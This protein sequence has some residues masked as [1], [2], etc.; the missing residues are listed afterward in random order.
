M[1]HNIS[2]LAENERKTIRRTLLQSGINSCSDKA[3]LAAYLAE[4]YAEQGHTARAYGYLL[5]A[6]R[7]GISIPDN[8]LEDFA[9]EVRAMSKEDLASDYEAALLIGCELQNDLANKILFLQIAADSSDDVY[10]VAALK[11]ADL[12]T[13]SIRYKKQSDHYYA[14]A[15]SKGNPDLLSCFTGRYYRKETE[16]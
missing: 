8:I 1:K 5:Q 16:K 9:K 12:L 2:I 6:S 4:V 11:L 14:L 13:C 10:G 15:A 7:L 3:K